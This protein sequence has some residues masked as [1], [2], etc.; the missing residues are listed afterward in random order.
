MKIVELRTLIRL[1]LSEARPSRPSRPD[2][3]PAPIEE[4]LIGGSRCN[5]VF[6]K[7]IDGTMPARDYLDNVS[8][9][10]KKVL[11]RYLQNFSDGHRLNPTQFKVERKMTVTVGTATREAPVVA[12]K[13]FQARLFGVLDGTLNGKSRLVLT[14]G[15]TKK[16]DLTPSIEFERAVSI[17]EEHETARTR[18]R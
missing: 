8:A 6:A 16:R 7:K 18:R 11:L 2:A 3:P 15:F 4:V 13:S 14:H 1:L 9:A 10:D 5:I 12:F 17:F